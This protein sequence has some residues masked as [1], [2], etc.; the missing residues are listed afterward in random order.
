MCINFESRRVSL[1][2]FPSGLPTSVNLKGFYIML[3]FMTWSNNLRVRKK[4]NVHQRK[5]FL[6]TTASVYRSSSMR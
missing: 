1:K 3:S 2:Q 5:R 4:A 6:T